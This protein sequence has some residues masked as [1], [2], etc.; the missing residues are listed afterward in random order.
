MSLDVQVSIEEN[1]DNP[2]NETAVPVVGEEMMLFIDYINM[3]AVDIY[4]V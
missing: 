3:P 2:T 4:G 1:I